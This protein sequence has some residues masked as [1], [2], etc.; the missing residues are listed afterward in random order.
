MEFTQEQK[1]YVEIVQKV[2]DDAEFKKALFRD[3]VETIENFMGKK[4]N[5]P[6]GK[7]LVIKDQTDESTLY[8]N[9]PA[10]QNLEDVELNE[11]QLEA[12]AGGKGILDVIVDLFQLSTPKI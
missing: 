4:I 5:L 8:I 7:T 9:I 10:E 11:R 1:L 12:V 2:W 3:P 6:E